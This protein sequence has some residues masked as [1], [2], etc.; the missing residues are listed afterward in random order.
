MTPLYVMLYKLYLIQHLDLIKDI[1]NIVKKLI[2]SI[3]KQYNVCFQLPHLDEIK[4]CSFVNGDI[5]FDCIYHIVYQVK[6]VPLKFQWHADRFH[7]LFCKHR[8]GQ[9]GYTYHI[10][11]QSISLYLNFRESLLSID[12]LIEPRLFSHTRPYHNTFSCSL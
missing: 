7:T 5:W 8:I 3:Q 9:F 11:K 1:Q 4:N 6:I 10:N 2:F 12:K